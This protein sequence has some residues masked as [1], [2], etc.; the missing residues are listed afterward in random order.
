M[1]RAGGFKRDQVMFAKVHRIY[2]LEGSYM[3]AMKCLIRQN[4]GDLEQAKVYWFW[5]KVKFH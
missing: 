5:L 4:L 2:Q 1:N 3:G